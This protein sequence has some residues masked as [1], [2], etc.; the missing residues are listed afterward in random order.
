MENLDSQDAAAEV[1]LEY[2]ILTV[3]WQRTEI[4]EQH[5]CNPPVLE[6]SAFYSPSKAGAQISKKKNISV[7]LLFVGMIYRSNIKKV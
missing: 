5:R 7:Q 1:R 6:S 3:L 4:Q 2:D